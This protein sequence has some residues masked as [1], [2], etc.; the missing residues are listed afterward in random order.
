[1]TAIDA[2]F[3]GRRGSFELDVAFSVPAR[4]VTALFGPS[5]CGKTMVL[6]CIAGLERLAEGRLAVNGRIWQDGNT[7]VPTHQRAIGYVFQEASLFPHLSVRANLLYGQKRSRKNASPLAIEDVSDLLGLAHLLDRSPRHLSGGERQRA[8][9]A[10]ALLSGPEILLMDEPLAALDRLSKNDIL[11]YLE[12]LQSEL[13]IPIVYVS[14]DIAEIE[15]LAD[16][17]VL[18]Q[19]GRVEAA[20][21][22][23]ELLSDPALP[24]ARMPEA[25]S[26]VSGRIGA[27]D[28]EFG[29][30]TVLAGEAE[31]LVPGRIG[32]VGD[33]CRLRIVASDVGISRSR[34]RDGSSILNGPLAQI[35]GAQPFGEHQMTV[36]LRIGKAGQGAPLLA[37]ITR[38]SWVTLGL[39]P[40]EVV[41]ALVK[42]V[43]LADDR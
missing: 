41:H 5:G 1:M 4:G 6:R 16:H 34:A 7:F 21:A 37:R 26:V 43:V 13:A 27:Y 3:K 20:G 36:F 38:K 23:A 42:S 15:R 33:N 14:H 39:Q 17:M 40:G 12:R 19:Q 24:M 30:S 25:A 31:F 8:A 2:R 35:T 22:L 28:T 29:L 32:A 9:I 10:R 18:M 11:P